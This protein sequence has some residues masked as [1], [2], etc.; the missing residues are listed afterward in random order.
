MLA[1][2]FIILGT[3]W[4]YGHQPMDQLFSVA[5]RES[6]SILICIHYRGPFYTPQLLGLSAPL[7]INLSLAGLV[8]MLTRSAQ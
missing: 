2:V 7:A 3:E 6:I 4:S 1:A 5:G 8:Q